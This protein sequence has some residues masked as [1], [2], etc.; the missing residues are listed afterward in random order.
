MAEAIQI[1]LYPDPRLKKP[2][3]SVKQFTPDLRELADTMLALMREHHGVGLAAPQIGKNIRLFVMNATG[4]PEDD[5]V[6]LNPILTEAEGDDEA[7]EGCLSIP[8]LRVK[9]VRAKRLQMDAQDLEGKPIHEISEGFVAR[10]WQHE[11]DHLNG[12]LLIDRMGAV[13]KITNRGLLKDL[14]EQYRRKVSTKGT[15]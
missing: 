15:K 10:V 5:R 13:A 14:E 4:K 2:S 6:Y 3:T 1:V 12:V 8:E 7:E 11:A 9:V